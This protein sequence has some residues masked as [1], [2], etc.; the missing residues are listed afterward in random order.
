QLRGGEELPAH[1]A[2][3]FAWSQFHPETLVWTP[4]DR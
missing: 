1:E 4:L 3:W 2:F